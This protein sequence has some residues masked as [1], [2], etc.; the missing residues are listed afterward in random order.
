MLGS[1]DNNI[2]IDYFT[3][4]VAG[5]A[6][7]IVESYPSY[8]MCP[9]G[10]LDRDGTHAIVVINVVTSFSSILWESVT[11]Y[12][13]TA[14]KVSQGVMRIVAGTAFVR[15]TNGREKSARVMLGNCF[16]S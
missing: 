7:G 1:I 15:T 14:D 3:F 4:Q 16:I 9:F 6:M 12:A 5:C 13:A 2:A 11:S 10:E 8:V